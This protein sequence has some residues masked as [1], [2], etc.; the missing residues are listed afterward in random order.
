[1]DDGNYGINLRAEITYCQNSKFPY[2]QQQTIYIKRKPQTLPVCQHNIFF[3]E[4]ALRSKPDMTIC[5]GKLTKKQTKN[6][7]SRL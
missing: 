5:K 3:C 6:L 7:E 1:M 2:A 4:Y